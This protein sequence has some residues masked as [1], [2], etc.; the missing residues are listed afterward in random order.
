MFR[1]RLAEARPVCGCVDAKKPNLTIPPRGTAELEVVMNTRRIPQ[2]Q[3]NQPKSVNII[4]TLASVPQSKGEK[5]FSSNCI[6]TVS[7]LAWTNLRFSAD[8]IGFG[9]IPIGQTAQKTMDIE[10][11][12]DPNWK[13][14]ESR[15]AQPPARRDD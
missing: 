14:R 1:L 2:T 3:L 5:M 10:N 12:G 15:A 8:D 9:A 6:L 4:V 13:I 7:C 11:V